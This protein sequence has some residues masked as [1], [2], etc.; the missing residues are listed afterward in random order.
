MFFIAHFL[1]KI[2]IDWLID[3]TW[4]G[5]LQSLIF[6]YWHLAQFVPDLFYF[7]FFLLWLKLEHNAWET[8]LI[9][10]FEMKYLANH[11]GSLELFKCDIYSSKGETFK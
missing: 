8:V 9:G 11:H 6:P 5:V 4:Q 10:Q 3:L 2:L 1:K 7:I